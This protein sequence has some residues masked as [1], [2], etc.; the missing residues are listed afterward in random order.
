MRIQEFLLALSFFTRL[1]IYRIF[2]RDFSGMA[3][4]QAAWA[5]PLVGML[6]NAVMAGVYMVMIST[7]MVHGIAAWIALGAQL[8][9]TGGLHEDGLADTADGLAQG[10]NRQ[11]KLAIMRDS[12]IGTFGVLALMVI[13]TIRTKCMAQFGNDIFWVLI[14]TGACSRAAIAVMMYQLPNARE[15]GLSASA[16]KPN[17]NQLVIALLI[18]LFTLLLTGHAFMGVIL[19]AI[20]LAVV[21]QIARSQFGGITGD[22]LGAVQQL[23]ETVLWV[24]LAR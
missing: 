22:V 12:R 11:E 9:L 13:L 23:S 18:G 4:A 16:G 19:L 17:G 21:Q 2:W 5:F 7:G 24:L 1:P 10:R 3:L 20:T 8:I 15:D 14:A 6:V